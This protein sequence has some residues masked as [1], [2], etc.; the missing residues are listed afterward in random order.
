MHPTDEVVNEPE[1]G[2]GLTLRYCKYKETET[3]APIRNATLFT[4]FRSMTAFALR[5]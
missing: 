5:F 1:A 2:H 3:A 4:E